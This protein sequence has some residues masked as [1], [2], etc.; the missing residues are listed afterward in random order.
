M[1]GVI[2][3]GGFAVF[4]EADSAEAA[5][6]DSMPRYTDLAN[7]GNDVMQDLEA[8]FMAGGTVQLVITGNDTDG[9]A[10]NTRAPMMSD[11]VISEIMW[12]RDASGSTEADKKAKQ[13]IEIYNTTDTDITLLAAAAADGVD[14]RVCL[15]PFYLSGF[16]ESDSGYGD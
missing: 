1:R 7:T 4:G 13:W 11:L 5:G 15:Y 9:S 10:D 14:G 6:L 3:A 2:K 8:F 12:G 16:G